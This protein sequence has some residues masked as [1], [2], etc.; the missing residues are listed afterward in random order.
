MSTFVIRRVKTL[1]GAGLAKWP[2]PQKPAIQAAMSGYVSIHVTMPNKRGRHLARPV[3]SAHNM[4]YLCK[5]RSSSRPASVRTASGTC[6]ASTGPQSRHLRLNSRT[7]VCPCYLPCAPC[8]PAH[9]PAFNPNP[10]MYAMHSAKP[11]H[12][13]SPLLFAMRATQSGPTLRRLT[14]TLPC[15]LCIQPNPHYGVSPAICHVRHAVRPC[16][17]AL[18]LEFRTYTMH[19]AKSTLQR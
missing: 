10:A 18:T 1:S 12:R 7:G 4:K 5:P 8:S 17:P 6:T 3:R 15:T 14:Q 9:A 11:T 13:R 16:N 2:A 19:S